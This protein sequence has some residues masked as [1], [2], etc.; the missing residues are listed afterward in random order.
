[1]IQI[2]EMAKKR[3]KALMLNQE[4]QH[5]KKIEGL[6]LV[7]KG[8]IPNVEYSLAFVEAGKKEPSDTSVEVEGIQVFME[9]KHASFLEDVKIDFINSLERSGFKVDNPKVIT[10]KPV[11]TPGA[12]AD[13]T[14][15]E[16]KAVQKVLDTEINPAV[17]GHGGYISLVD[18]K[19]QVAYIRLGGGCQGCGMADVT[20]KQGVVVAIKKAIPEIKEVLDVT[21]H[22]GGSNPY[23]SPGK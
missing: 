2:T 17:A 7:V 10:A 6:R 18:V 15:P 8:M 1:M 5:D 22:A 3:I 20:L 9:A 11:E 23:F 16:A 19:D 21:D 13:L 12:K 4:E 14:T